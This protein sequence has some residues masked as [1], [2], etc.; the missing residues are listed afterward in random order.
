MLEIQIHASDS[1]RWRRN[2][3]LLV[4]LLFAVYVGYVVREIWLPLMIAF[5]IAMVL[6][7]LVDK[8]E[9]RGWSRLKG[10]VVI[11]ALFFALLGGGLTFAVPAVVGQTTA[12]TREIG[13]YLPSDTGKNAESE[14]RHKLKVLLM[15]MRATPVVEN[16]VLRASGQISNAFTH[17]NAWFG[18][19]AEAALGNLL[20][21]IIIPLV[22]FY[23]L[24]DLHLIYARLL[25]MIPRQ[26]RATAQNLL[27][28][29]SSIFA[30]YLRGLMIVC[31]LNGLATFLLLWKFGVPNAAGLAGISGVMYMV[32]YIGAALTILLVGGVCLMASKPVLLIVFLM[33]LLH[34]VFFDQI[35]TPRIV[36]Q[37]VGLHPILSIIALLMGATLLG[38]PG[39]ILAV[40]IAATVQMILLAIF[41]KLGSPIEVPTG[42]QLHNRV[43]AANNLPAPPDEPE[44]ANATQ[45]TGTMAQVSAAHQTIVDAVDEAE[46]AEA[47]AS[48]PSSPLL[49]QSPAQ[50][51][52]LD[53][54]AEEGRKPAPGLL[55]GTNKTHYSSS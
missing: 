33:V 30:R 23:A 36:G 31:A 3:A 16:T 18:K 20:W 11:Y 37:H 42:E 49:A 19:A 14:T 21:V 46:I 7:P 27:N 53:D 8:M 12:I 26:S 47:T 2:G 50:A 6:D 17:A 45:P 51:K 28:E 1:G 9:S 5:L 24:K 40:P 44:Q 52:V 39:M 55:T 4:G 48:K 25:L 13:Q 35:V 29:V 38:I 54:E 15:R 34:H 32:P 10:A 41:P 22:S 43:E